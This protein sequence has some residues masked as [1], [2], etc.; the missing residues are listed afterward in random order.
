[1]VLCMIRSILKYEVNKLHIVDNRVINFYMDW[2][3]SYL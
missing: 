2:D 3:I 1:M